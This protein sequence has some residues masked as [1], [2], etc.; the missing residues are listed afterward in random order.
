MKLR[1]P[2]LFVMASFHLWVAYVLF[3]GHPA[4]EVRTMIFCIGLPGFYFST[5]IYPGVHSGDYSALMVSMGLVNTGFIWGIIEALGV[6][7]R[8]IFLKVKPT[9]QPPQVGKRGQ[10]A[11]IDIDD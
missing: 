10:A 8:K 11:E 2:L 4:Q 5:L 9:S 7:F 1:A 6:C 3:K